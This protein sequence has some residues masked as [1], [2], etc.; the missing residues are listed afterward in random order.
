MR[1]EIIAAKTNLEIPNILTIFDKDVAE[2]DYFMVAR[3]IASQKMHSNQFRTQL[4]LDEER[5]K[6]LP[7]IAHIA[8]LYDKEDPHGINALVSLSHIIDPH[9]IKDSTQ[10]KTL[11]QIIKDQS[12]QGLRWF[13][14]IDFDPSSKNSDGINVL[15][16][17]SEIASDSAS[18]TYLNMAKMLI[19]AKKSTA[20]LLK[21]RGP[22]RIRTK[23]GKDLEGLEG[24]LSDL[25]IFGLEK[26][27]IRLSEFKPLRGDDGRIV[28]PHSFEKTLKI[29][30]SNEVRTDNLLRLYN[31]HSGVKIKKENLP[32][33]LSTPELVEDNFVRPFT[34]EDDDSLDKIIFSSI[35]IESTAAPSSKPYRRN[36]GKIR[37]PL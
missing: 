35:H 9:N 21:E 10:N 15:E 24:N 13:L 20:S 12:L 29:I 28:Q 26:D 11:T 3:K 16:Y 5:Q 31:T 34:S 8:A 17:L 2:I 1:T 18:L 22:L 4:C 19:G 33:N 32:R 14:A 25:V 36:G 37:M 30:F 7:K 6:Y 23:E 27:I